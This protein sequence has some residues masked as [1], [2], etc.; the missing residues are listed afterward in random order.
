[1]EYIDFSIEIQF[2]TAR[3]GGKGGQNV[4]K[5]ETMVEGRWVIEKSTFFNEEQKLMIQ[6][7][8][9]NRI[10]RQGILIVQSQESRSQLENKRIVSDTMMQLV[11][12]AIQI[13]TP[14]IATKIPKAV[15]E[16]NKESKIK[17]A[18]LKMNRKKWHI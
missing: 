10:S 7:K 17:H 18:Q 3:S 11:H 2:K 5:V 12:E 16:R 4:N 15:K 13:K 1:M 6:Q 9:K 8:L 14:R